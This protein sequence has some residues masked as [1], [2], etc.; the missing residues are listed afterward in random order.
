[1]HKK[2][3]LIVEDQ[4]DNRIIYST[5]LEHAGFDVLEAK[6]GEEGVRCAYEHH[7]DL[8]LMDLSMP[9]LDGWEAVRRLKSDPEMAGTP[10]CAISAH[11]PCDGDAERAQDSG[12]ECYLTKPL[13][14]RE[15]LEEVEKR[16]GPAGEV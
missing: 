11:V 8:I 12:F 5:I 6:N 9:V 2:T 16:I 13:D 7:P 10:V 3:V 14:P 1:M 15:V 4:P